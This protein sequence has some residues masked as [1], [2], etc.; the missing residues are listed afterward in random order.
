ME[1]ESRWQAVVTGGDI[2]R[3]DEAEWPRAWVGSSGCSR[4]LNRSLTWTLR[5]ARGQGFLTEGS[6][7]GPP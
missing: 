1:E 7:P 4:E 3:Q 5:W 6:I 2:S